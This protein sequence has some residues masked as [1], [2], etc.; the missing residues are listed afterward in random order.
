MEASTKE[1]DV[2]HFGDERLAAALAGENGVDGPGGGAGVDGGTSIGRLGCMKLE[3]KVTER[4]K[5]KDR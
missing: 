3:P 1:F 5:R 2:N 4:E